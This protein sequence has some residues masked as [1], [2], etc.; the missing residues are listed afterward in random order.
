MRRKK[1]Q[2]GWKITNETDSVDIDQ[3]CLGISPWRPSIPSDVSDHIHKNRGLHIQIRHNGDKQTFA[4]ANDR[5]RL[6][7]SAP[8][9][10][11]SLKELVSEIY[12]SGCI[13][14]MNEAS[15]YADHFN[16]AVNRAEDLIIKLKGDKK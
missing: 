16:Q 7:T 3:K 8:E 10:L 9:L 14:Y 1:N 4:Q 5:A 2:T 12:Q 13:E 11:E 15:V 6:I